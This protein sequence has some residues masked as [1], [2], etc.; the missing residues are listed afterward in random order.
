VGPN[1]PLRAARERTESREVPGECMSRREVARAVNAYL[2]RSTGRVYDF[3]GHHLAK[4][5]RGV[6]RWPMA[7]YRAALRHV[8][9]ALTDAELGFNPPRRGAPRRRARNAHAPG[10]DRPA[11]PT[12]RGGAHHGVGGAGH[13]AAGREHRRGHRARRRG[14]AVGEPGAPARPAGPGRGALAG[15]RG[16]AGPA[17]AAGPV[18]AARVRRAGRSPTVWRAGRSPTVWRAGRSPTAWHAGGSVRRPDRRARVTRAPRGSPVGRHRHRRPTCRD[19][20]PRPRAPAELA[21]RGPG[22]T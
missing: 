17:R 9:G 2:Y 11:R 7:A 1:E 14:R 21:R 19:R 18:G 22:G 3:D 6:H 5:E 15:G 13:P 20:R 10:L 8:L 16:V 12:T 4:L